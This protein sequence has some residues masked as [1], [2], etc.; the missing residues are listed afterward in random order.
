MSTLKFAEVH[1]LVVFLSKPT[2]CEGFKQ[3]VDFLNANPIRYAL[4]VNPTMYISCIEQFW[5]TAKA[6]SINGEAQIHAKN[7]TDEAVYKELDDILVRAA[8]TAS[9]LKAK[10]DSGN[11]NKT[12]SKATPNESS[13]Q[14]TDSGGGPRCQDT[15]RDTIAQTRSERVSKLSNDSLLASDNP[16]HTLGDYSKLSHEGYK[17][18]IELPV[19][20]SVVPPR[21]EPIWLV[22]NGCSFHGLRS[23]DPNQHIKD[24]L[25]LV[26][27][28][29]L[30]VANRERTHMRLF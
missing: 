4:T 25:K 1:N 8:T 2:E 16:I 9:S 20:N 12:Q 23:E 19:G 13:S 5:T 28:L 27:L 6:K 7:V 14:G 10:H 30:D 15:M 17:T 29:D 18:T 3:I 24:F 21:S 22:Q 26:D 11:I